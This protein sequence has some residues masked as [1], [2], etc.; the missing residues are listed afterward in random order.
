MGFLE[1]KLLISLIFCQIT[2]KEQKLHGGIGKDC[3]LEMRIWAGLYQA[4]VA[5]HR[6]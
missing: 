4:R 3:L 5:S 6:K 1:R 2:A